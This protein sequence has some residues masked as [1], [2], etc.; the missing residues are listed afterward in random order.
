MT[1]PPL[2]LICKRNSGPKRFL[3]LLGMK[4]IGNIGVLF[5]KYF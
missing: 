1:R 3:L 5:A 2:Q 4:I